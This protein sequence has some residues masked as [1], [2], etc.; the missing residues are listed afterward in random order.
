MLRDAPDP[1]PLSAWA[2]RNQAG[3]SAHLD[4]GHGD[5]DDRRWDACSRLAPTC[6]SWT[7]ATRFVVAGTASAWGD[8]RR[9]TLTFEHGWG[10]P[11]IILRA[12]GAY[13]NRLGLPAH[14]L[15]N[16]EERPFQFTR[17]TRSSRC[18]CWLGVLTV[19]RGQLRPAGQTPV[20]DQSGVQPRS[21]D[22]VGGRRPHDL[23]ADR[24]RLTRQ[25]GPGRARGRWP[26]GSADVDEPSMVSLVICT[27]EGIPFLGEPSGNGP[28]DFGTGLARCG[29]GC[30]PRS[31]HNLLPT[32]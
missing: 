29:S 27:S 15:R 13:H 19:F 31:A 22:A 26:H 7:A 17:S 10:N 14:A 18:S 23:P 21:D 20:V 3:D 8:D 16:E 30:S 9:L 6:R 1:Q 25:L 11:W 32:S 5:S 28:S 12:H 4:G 24:Q 2:D